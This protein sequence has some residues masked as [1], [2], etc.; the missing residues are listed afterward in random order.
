MSV[1]PV[2]Q[3]DA[4]STC[5]PNFLDRRVVCF[6]A[7]FLLVDVFAR[8]VFRFG[9][10]QFLMSPGQYIYG[11]PHNTT[12]IILKKKMSLCRTSGCVD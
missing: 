8:V 11:P 10:I 4:F 3:V 1:L 2:C 7:G 9:G 12:Y 6:A 5:R